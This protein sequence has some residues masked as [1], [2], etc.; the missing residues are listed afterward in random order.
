[1]GR[2]IGLVLMVTAMY[3]GMEVYTKGTEHALGGAFARFAAEGEA[4]GPYDAGETTPQRA[5][6][7]VKR[8]HQVASERRSKLLDD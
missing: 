6:T 7:A 2:L 1:M 5:G 3:V 4:E 8:A